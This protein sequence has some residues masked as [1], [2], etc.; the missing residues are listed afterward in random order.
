MEFNKDKVDEYTLALLYL[1]M[2]EENNYAR[3]AWK[4]F[5]WDTMNRLCE[6]GYI[7]DPKNKSKSVAVTE[8][9]FNKAKELFQKF[10]GEGNE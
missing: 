5:D 4:N 7:F 3:M 9:G 8:E 2:W 10:F 1:V 6:K